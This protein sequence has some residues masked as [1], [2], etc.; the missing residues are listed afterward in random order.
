MPKDVLEIMK[1]T[2][3]MSIMPVRY[4]DNRDKYKD[5]GLNHKDLLLL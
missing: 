2:E 3:G 1:H 4:V 5:I